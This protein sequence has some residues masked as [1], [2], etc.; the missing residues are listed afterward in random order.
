MR[1]LISGGGTGGHVY[2]ALAVAAQLPNAQPANLFVANAAVEPLSLLW[3]GSVGGM[4]QELVERAGLSFYGIETGKLHGMDAK[5]I[6]TSLGKMTSGVRQSLRLLRNFQPHVCFVTGGYVCAPVVIACWL[7]RVPVLI[8]LP[9]IVPGSAIRWL[10]KLAQRVAVSFPQAAA[11][12]GGVV[13]QGKAVV[14]GYPVRAELVELT[15]PFSL[16]P[17]PSPSNGEGGKKVLRPPS[18]PGG[19]NRQA[20]RCQLAQRLQHDFGE[21]DQAPLLLVWGGSQGSRNIN[22]C[23]WAALPQLLPEAYMLHVVGTRDWPLLEVAVAQAQ[24]DPALAQRYHPVAY[25]HDEMMLALAAADLTVARAGAST[26]GEFTVARLPSILVP[27]LGVN[28]HQNAEVLTQAG[29]ALTIADANLA[30]NFTTTVLALLRNA[31]QRR[32]MEAALARLAQPDA[33]L[34]IA[35]EVWGLAKEK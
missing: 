3:A 29:A 12:F 6:F 11:A 34:H 7:R 10:S 19:Q 24:V 23:T 9:D 30:Q 2:P 1:V 14:T 21:C 32:E 17:N 33:A 15:Y 13:P 4:E 31:D 5:T 26:L 8:Y 28:Q 16:T 35:Q 18:P 27:L 20:V 25:L 22:Q